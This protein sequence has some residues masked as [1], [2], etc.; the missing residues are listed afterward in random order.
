MHNKYIHVVYNERSSSLETFP[1]SW[2][3]V[4]VWRRCVPRGVAEGGEGGFID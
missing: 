3:K 4:G 2:M 1:F